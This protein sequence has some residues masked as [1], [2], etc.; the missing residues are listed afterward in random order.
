MCWFAK[1]NAFALKSRE[2]QKINKKEIYIIVDV[3]TGTG[4]GQ[5]YFADND[6]TPIGTTQLLCSE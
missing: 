2:A 5:I 6:Q 3:N 1:N 4:K